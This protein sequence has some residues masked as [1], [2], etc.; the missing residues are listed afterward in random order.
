M[1]T[2]TAS[3]DVLTQTIQGLG[4]VSVVDFAREQ[5]KG[6]LQQKIAYYQ[7][8]V[9]FF[10]QKYGLAFA[11]FGEQFE[12]IKPWSI[13]EKED[14]SLLWETALDALNAYRQDLLALNQ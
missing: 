9:D 4:Y 6:I 10:E 12:Q 11:Q 3:T 1:A 2:P 8:R 5:T 13:I 14:D 7:S